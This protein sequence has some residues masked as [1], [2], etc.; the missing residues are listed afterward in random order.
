MYSKNAIKRWSSHRSSRAWVW[1]L[2]R[3]R[4][5]VFFDTDQDYD[6]YRGQ[7]RINPPS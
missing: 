6:R 5:I 2:F 7:Y 1:I 3:A 4:I